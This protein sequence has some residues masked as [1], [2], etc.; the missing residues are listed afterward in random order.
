MRGIET[1]CSICGC[2]GYVMG[3][4]SFYYDVCVDS[5]ACRRRAIRNKE[6][7]INSL[8]NKNE[9]LEKEIKELKEQCHG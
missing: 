5:D 2:T 9:S 8:K 6:R 4:P 7:E 1:K 3:L